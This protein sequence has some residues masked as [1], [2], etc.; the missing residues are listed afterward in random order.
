MFALWFLSDLALA[1][2]E[3]GN[4]IPGET[5]VLNRV[6]SFVGLFIL[7]G[8][9]W[10]ISENRNKINWRPV[11]WGVGL[12]LVLGLI[13][14]SPGVSEFFYAVVGG[15]VRRLLSFS[16]E[17]ATFIFASIEPHAIATG[18]IPGGE[19]KMAEG[20]SPPVKTFAFWI[21]P[22]IVFFSSL[23]SVLYFLGVMQWIVRGL[24]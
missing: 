4:F 21:L 18:P 3:S 14:L 6:M 2:N 8:L 23:M 10:V 20:V 13:L 16:E 17:G 5:T 22:T 9:A 1:A 11:I 19:L 12:Q 7:V 15:G 24:A